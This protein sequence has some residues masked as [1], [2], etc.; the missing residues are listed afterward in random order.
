MLISYQGQP[1]LDGEDGLLLVMVLGRASE[2]ALR[3]WLLGG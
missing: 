3:G 2:P 1:I